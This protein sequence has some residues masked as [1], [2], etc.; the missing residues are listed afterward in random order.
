MTPQ[1]PEEYINS[2]LVCI[3]R[4]NFT[5]E[6]N[7]WDGDLLVDHNDSDSDSDK[8]IDEISIRLI[9][10]IW[11]QIMADM[12]NGRGDGEDNLNDGI[13]EL[14][15]EF[16]E[17]SDLS[18]D[19]IDN[20]IHS[21]K[22]I[23]LKLVNKIVEDAVADDELQ[24]WYEPPGD[25][26]REYLYNIDSIIDTTFL[27][28]DKTMEHVRCWFDYN[29]YKKLHKKNK[30]DCQKN[31]SN[32][33]ESSF[34]TPQEL[35]NALC[36]FL[37]V[38]HGTKMARTEVTRYLTKYIKENSLQSDLDMRTIIPDNKLIEL[39]E[40]NEDDKLAFFSLQKYLNKHFKK[41]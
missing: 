27:V 29:L 34:A 2:D 19:I 8:T 32:K 31:T 3:A 15:P 24:E 13:S 7:K 12:T 20:F 23:I 41:N 16:I 25:W 22:N 28:T 4:K 30:Q 37:K 39:L 10:L 38:E 17:V 33:K 26:I 9:N 35:S 36:D 6:Y 18:P 14:S 21:N 5:P 1:T 40:L 11:R